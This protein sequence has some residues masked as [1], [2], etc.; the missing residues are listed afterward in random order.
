MALKSNFCQLE[1]KAIEGLCQD[2]EARVQRGDVV[3]EVEAEAEVDEGV[4]VEGE[5]EAE[6]Q[7]RKGE[8]GVG[9]EVKAGGETGAG[10][11]NETDVMEKSTVM[12]NTW[13]M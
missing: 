12:M 10:I 3:K 2:P 11:E 7:A 9:V 4:E 5:K 8:E 6:V 13:I 1:L